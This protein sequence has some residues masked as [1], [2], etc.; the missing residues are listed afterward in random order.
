MVIVTHTK[1]MLTSPGYVKAGWKRREKNFTSIPDNCL[2]CTKCKNDRPFRAHHC[3]HCGKCTLKMDHHCPWVANCVGYGNQKFFYQFLFYATFGDLVG[4]IILITR[5][6]Y[7]QSE[8]S[9][10]LEKVVIESVLDVIWTLRKPIFIVMSSVL[11]ASMTFSIGLLFYFQTK[12]LMYNSTTIENLTYTNFSD[13]PWYHQDKLHNFK[14]VMG[15]NVYEWFIPVFKPNIYNSG[16]SNY[17]PNTLKHCENFD[18]QNNNIYFQLGSLE[19][20][21]SNRNSIQL[22]P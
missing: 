8:E 2:F 9:N 3:K 16:Y 11:A 21:Q 14:T 15:E 10:K 7:I 18:K 13:S 6:F 19:I 22:E 4:F 12:M 5:L 20:D 17:T 1:S